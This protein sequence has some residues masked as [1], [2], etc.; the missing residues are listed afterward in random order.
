MYKARERIH[1]S[2]A[3]LRL[4]A[5]PTSRVELQTPIRTETAFQGFA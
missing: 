4:L 1:R 2:I 5:T 3:D